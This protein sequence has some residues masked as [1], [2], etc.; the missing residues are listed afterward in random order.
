MAN[1]KQKNEAKRLDT[2]ELE[3]PETLF[4]RDIE[5]KVFQGIILQCLARIEGIALVEGNFIDNIFNRG[6]LE[7][8]KGIYAE[9]DNKSPS[10]K[11]KI[12]V[13]I[14]YGYSIPEKAE[15]IQNLCREEITRLTGLHVSNVHIIFKNILLDEYKRDSLITD[16]AE[17]GAGLKRTSSIEEEYNDEF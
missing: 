5:T 11:V 1:N 3:L 4:V 8:I 10:V 2:K 13:N 6:T 17:S 15:E 12:E 14:Y 7:G 16:P 9:Q